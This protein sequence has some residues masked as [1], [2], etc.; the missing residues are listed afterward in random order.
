MYIDD[1]INNSRQ[2][3]SRRIE[4][5]YGKTNGQCHRD[6]TNYT[7]VSYVSAEKPKSEGKDSSIYEQMYGSFTNY[8][9]ATNKPWNIRQY[10]YDGN[11]L[12]AYTINPCAAGIYSEHKR[13]EEAFK[14]LYNNIM[15]GYNVVAKG[16]YILPE[17]VK[18]D[19]HYLMEY[20]TDL[21]T[22]TLWYSDYSDRLFFTK[23]CYAYY[24]INMDNNKETR[25]YV[26]LITVFILLETLLFAIFWYV[27]KKA[28]TKLNVYDFNKLKDKIRFANRFPLHL[29]GKTT[30]KQ[31]VTDVDYEVLLHKINPINFMNPY[32]EEK[33]RIANDLY[34]ALLKSKGNETIIR[35]IEE[36]A[37]ETLK[38]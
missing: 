29:F 7:L 18:T 12:R 21:G 37:K 16:Y 22:D 28:M 33:V 15:E 27:K 20:H 38:I 9:V 23:H 4:I 1:E 35:M 32:D 5:Y 10:K 17:K 26:F 34:S 13:P 36:K 3:I 25:E 6:E 14:T 2:D 24:I 11:L 8:F 19:Y 31:S 30:N